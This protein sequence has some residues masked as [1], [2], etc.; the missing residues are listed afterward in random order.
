MNSSA[1]YLAPLVQLSSTD[2]LF[3]NVQ[4]AQINE[5][6]GYTAALSNVQLTP[7]ESA[8][9]RL[10]FSIQNDTVGGFHSA[11]T[12]I[13]VD[14]NTYFTETATI[15]DAYESYYTKGLPFPAGV[16]N[17]LLA[18]AYQGSLA[19]Y[20]PNVLSAW[21]MLDLD[22]Y[23]QPNPKSN[24]SR[25][26]ETSE[27][28]VYPNPTTGRIVIESNELFHELNQNVS[29]ELVDIFGRLVFSDDVEFSGYSYGFYIE[30]QPKGVYQLILEYNGTL[31]YHSIILK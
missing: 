24:R 23:G 2:D 30:D 16:E 25:N 8:L 3:N 19:E 15:M 20:G 31:E 7:N 13:S 26:L 5:D 17:D 21:V 9:G 10:Y 29:I 6:L 27:V 28:L 1:A 22:V 11:A 14:T 4:K 18:I 12:A